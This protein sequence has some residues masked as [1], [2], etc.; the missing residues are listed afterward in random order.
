MER[1]IVEVVNNLVS[2]RVLEIELPPD[3]AELAREADDNFYTAI[4]ATEAPGAT[5]RIALKLTLDDGAGKLRDLARRVAK[6][7]KDRPQ[8]RDRFNGLSV[9]GYA[10][11]SKLRRFIDILE[12]KLVSGEVFTRTSARSRSIQ[13]EDAYRVIERAYIENRE[14]LKLAATSSDWR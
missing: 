4:K 7:I 3:A 14:K 9:N 2:V 13:S 12:N 10:S 8:E 5:K 1:D 6:I 11:S